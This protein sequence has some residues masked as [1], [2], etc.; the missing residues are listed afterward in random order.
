MAMYSYKNNE[1][2]REIPHISHLILFTDKKT[3][4][5]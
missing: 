3:Y 4:Y 5:L 1:F 2:Y